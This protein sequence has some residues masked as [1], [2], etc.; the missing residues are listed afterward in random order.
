M[1]LAKELKRERTLT[2]DRVRQVLDE[3]TTQCP[4]HLPSLAT[5]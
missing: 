1:K 4:Q 2:G 3:T 5:V